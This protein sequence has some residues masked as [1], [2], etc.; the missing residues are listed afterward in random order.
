MIY[1]TRS[2]ILCFIFVRSYHGLQN[3]WRNQNQLSK[4]DIRRRILVVARHARAPRRRTVES[5]RDVTEGIVLF[6]ALNARAAFLERK[7]H[8]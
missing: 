5:R 6:D 3:W 8:N 7:N 1:D 4:T 2:I